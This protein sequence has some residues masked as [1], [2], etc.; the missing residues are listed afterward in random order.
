M[1]PQILTFIYKQT[2]ISNR[3]EDIPEFEIHHKPKVVNFYEKNT[4]F[5][6]IMKESKKVT[7]LSLDNI[8][9]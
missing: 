1:I 3:I 9:K 7:I 2:D 4:F 8:V 5:L 6:E